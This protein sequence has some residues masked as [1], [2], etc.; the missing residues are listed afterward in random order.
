L[1]ATGMTR[2]TTD[3]NQ[4][5][6]ATSHPAPID[7]QL[8]PFVLELT[9]SQANAETAGGAGIDA[10][11]RRAELVRARWRRGGPTM[12]TVGDAEIPTARGNV[13]VRRIRTHAVA[14]PQSALIYLHGGG[15]TMFSLDTHDRIMRELAARAGVIVI[16]VDYAL[17]PESKF[18][19]ALQQIVGVVQWLA[20]HGAKW[21][22]DPMR[23]ALGGDSS[24]ANLAVAAA[25]ML[26]DAGATDAVR[27]M[28]LAYGCFAGDPATLASDGYGADGN[29]L[30]S[31]EMATFWKNY[32]AHPADVRNPLASPL[33][34][35]LDGLPQTF[36]V[37]AQCDVLAAQNRAFTARLRAAG[38]TVEAREY[39]GATHSFLEAVSIADIAVRALADSAQWL[40]DCLC[41]PA[42]NAT[43]D[44]DSTHT[45][46]D[47]STH[48]AKRT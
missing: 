47:P 41:G 7:P 28:L 44:A 22:V 36:Q 15:W 43:V 1:D 38:V 9:Q 2:E 21:G 16:G 33:L 42:G 4:A 24:G 5:Q 3:R 31:Q 18:P 27:G 34:A 39:A 6:P 12:V 10:I 40:R 17:A 14:A 19:V 46:T 30:T 26:R 25:L 11:R 45:G 20:N 13:R 48:E 29:V 8:R 37:I 35:R 23:L 32:L